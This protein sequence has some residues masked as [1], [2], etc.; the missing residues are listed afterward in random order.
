[1]AKTGGEE[2]DLGVWGYTKAEVAA[3]VYVE[4]TVEVRISHIGGKDG[5]VLMKMNSSPVVRRAS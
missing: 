5:F 2:T 3:Q 4:S 1:M